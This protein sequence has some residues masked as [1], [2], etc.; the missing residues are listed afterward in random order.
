M[1]ILLIDKR[2]QDYETIV[3]AIDPAL[4]VGLVFDYYE[5]TF[6]TVKAR[7]GAL[8]HTNGTTQISVGLIQHNYRAPM[9]TMLAT[10]DVAPIAQVESQDPELERWTQFRDFITWCKTE[11]NAAHFDLMACALYSDPD[12]KY[13]IDTLTTQTGVTVRASSDDTGAASLGGDWFLESH[14]GVNLKTVY[15]TEAIDEYHGLLLRISPFG[16][17]STYDFKGVATGSVITWGGAGGNSSSVSS[18]IQSDVISIYSATYAHAALKSDGSVVAWGSQSEGGILSVNNNGTYTS[19]ASSLTSGVVSV[20]PTRSAFAALKSNGSVVTW[21]NSQYGGYS[22]EPYFPSPDILNSGVVA[23]YSTE[24]AFVALKSDGSVQAWGNGNNGGWLYNYDTV[25][26]DLTRSGVVS[27]YSSQYAFVALKSNGGLVMWGG[28]AYYIANVSSSISSGVVAV[29]STQYAW[30]ALKNDGRV[31]TW[32]DQNSGGNS[33]VY[34]TTTNSYTSVASSLT[35]GVVSIYSNGFAFAALKNDGS[36]VTWGDDRYGGN[37]SSVSSSLTSGV[38]ALCASGSA[39][40]A[41]KSDGRVITWGSGDDG[42]NSSSVSSS[43][44]SGVVAIY[45]NSYAFAA[46][47]SNGS[48][49]VWGRSQ[50]GGSGSFPDWIDNSGF[51]SVHSNPFSFAALKN[52]GSVITWGNTGDYYSVSSS[53]SSGIIGL[54]PNRESYAVLKTSASTFDL[55]GSVYTDMDRYTILRNKE[56][57]RRVNLTTLNNNVF[58]LSSSRDIQV[59]N[60]NIP[61]GTTL[62]IIIPTYVASSYSITSD[63]AIPNS[64]DSFIVACDESEPVTIS[65]TTYVNYGAFVYQVN[66]NGTYTKVTSATINGTTYALYGGDGVFSSGIV[67]LGLE[68][69]TLSASTFAVES[70][71]IFGDAS[72]AI[73]TRPTSNN[74]SV[75]IVYS[76]SNPAVATIDAS[77]NFITLVSA[78]DVSFTATQAA[79]S[80]YASATKTSNTLTVLR[81]TTSLSSFSVAGSKTFG[82][83]PF[84]ITAPTSDSSGAITYS[85][86]ATSVATIN[87]SSGIITLVAA[88]TATFTASQAAS[89]QYNAPTPVTSNTLTVALGTTSLSAFS[90]AESKTFEDAPFSTTAPTSASNG[91]ITFSSNATNVATIN[92]SSGIITLVAA[93]TVTFTA[94]QAAS[95]QYNA[96]TPVTSNTLTVAPAASDFSGSTFLVDSNKTFGDASFNITTAPTSIKSDGAITY[97]SSNPAV[98][99]I[100]TSGNFINLVG[101]GTVYFIATQLSTPQYASSVKNSNTLTVALGTTSLTSFSVAGSKTFGDA[102]FSITAPTS[103]SSGAITYSSNATGVA[104]INPSSGII[105]LVAAGTVTFTASQAESAQYESP[106]PVTSNTLTV[107]RGTTSLSSLSVAESK[108]FGDAPFSITV[109]TSDSSGAITYSSNATGVATINASSGIITLVAAGTATFTASQAESPQ[110]NAPTPVTSNTLTVSKGTTTLAFVSPPT[111]KILTDDAFTV[112]ASSASSGAITYTSSNTAR[113]TVGLTTGLVT[114]LDTGSVTITAAQASS[115]QY[116]APTN[117]TFTMTIGAA[118]NLSGQTVTTS[119]AGKN[120]TGIS[121]VGTNLTNI[122]L[123][124]TNLRNVDLSGADIS[125]ASFINTDLSGATNLPVFSTTQKLQLMRNSNNAAISEVQISTPL[126]GAEINAAITTPIPDIS[127]TTFVVKAPAYNVNNEKLVTVTAEDMANNESLYIPMNSG[128]TVKVNG[129]AYT[130]NGTNILNSSGSV[131]QFINVLGNPFR[132]YAGSIVGLNVSDQLNNIKL[133]GDGLYDILVSLFAAKT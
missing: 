59:I 56:S 80:Q 26:Y 124:N 12:W 28:Q 20:Y 104:T 60:P 75:A 19:V 58:T 49:V 111:T 22:T 16:K 117:T 2:V 63:A 129:V 66:A 81:G 45:S 71:K 102:P 133:N 82:A 53:L 9:F 112:V 91:A 72:F 94:S 99:T 93:G 65:G 110:Y 31:I 100:D 11:F 127:G 119:L 17:R 62:K 44:T 32:G 95:A 40:A 39:L 37:S 86:N 113:A 114:L 61:A 64:S 14:T 103:D 128:E 52:D 36:V 67:F 123:A 84:S 70:S 73:T 118:A 92:A 121:L 1:N 98:A 76:S 43:L 115:A 77:G 5:D 109:P 55:S 35:S 18:S 88:G 116:N 6:D 8:G 106:T 54:S 34:N 87:A 10:A 7:I 23:V 38:V 21:G 13:V 122:S 125:G 15:F 83:A 46:L 97:S 48:I 131:I 25:A 47:K 85:S 57:R 126:S 3:A 132:L 27:V 107:S 24:G 42:G 90:V 105:T 69:S 30:A 89:A 4:A 108:T 120:L 33:S 68:V 74:T 41:L 29:Y 51:V 78:G 101:G 96:P 50:Y 130:F 79:T